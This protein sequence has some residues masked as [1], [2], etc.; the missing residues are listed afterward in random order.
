M[1]SLVR[2]TA[3]ATPLFSSQDLYDQLRIKRSTTG[4]DSSLDAYV[5]AAVQWIEGLAGISIMKQTWT[6]RGDQ[7]PYNRDYDRDGYE[8]RYPLGKPILLPRGP[9][10]SID[11]FTYQDLNNQTQ[12]V[13]GS[14]YQ[15][16]LEERPPALYPPYGGFF[17]TALWV[18]GAMKIVFTCGMAGVD[19]DPKKVDS[20]VKMAV[21]FL[22]A[23]WN[24]NR[25]P[26][27]VNVSLQ[28]LPYALESM[29]WSVRKGYRF[30]WQEYYDSAYSTSR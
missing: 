21:K 19:D 20:D 8:R 18:P 12:N 6:L 4:D 26:V 17:P 5:E 14:N 24:E 11:T 25:E 29:L 10:L 1:S 27:P 13:T 22:V 28:K 30:D 3:P 15:L 7:F 2:T 23:H 16:A 9:V